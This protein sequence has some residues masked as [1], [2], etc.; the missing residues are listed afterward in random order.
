MPVSYTDAHIAY[1]EVVVVENQ[2]IFYLRGQKP[3]SPLQK[4]NPDVS[5]SIFYSDNAAQ[6]LVKNACNCSLSW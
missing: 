1:R 6:C 4:Y 3:P 2:I 5:I